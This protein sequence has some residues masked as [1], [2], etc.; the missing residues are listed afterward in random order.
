MLVKRRRVLELPS[1]LAFAITR[2]VFVAN[3]LRH[4][5]IVVESV[6]DVDALKPKLLIRIR[7]L[8]KTRKREDL[9]LPEA[10][11]WK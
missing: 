4:T 5:D 3:E 10:A 11:D 1:K 9:T 7:K 6:E 8:V 2:R